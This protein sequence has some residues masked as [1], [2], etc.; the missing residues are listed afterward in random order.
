M[1]DT[2]QVRISGD[3]AETVENALAA[4]N[5]D[6]ELPDIDRTRGRTAEGTV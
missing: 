2:F 4:I 6:D 5:D 1:T 3:D